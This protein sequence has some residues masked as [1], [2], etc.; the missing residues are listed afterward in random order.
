MRSFARDFSS[1]RRAPPNAASKPYLFSACFSPSVF[2]MS[3]CLALPWTNGLMPIAT[4]S[5]FYAPAA[6]SRT[7][8][9]YD[10][11][12]HTSRGTSSR[13]R[14]AATERQRPRVECLTGKMQHDAGIFANGVQHYRVRKFCCHLANDVDAFGLQ[15][16]Q[17]GESFWSIT[18]PLQYR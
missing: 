3:V 7:L 9:R 5:G 12:I 2:I 13:Y 8:W 11:E 16:S 6:R 10:R 17:M 15:L 1:S 4:P 18:V 14:H